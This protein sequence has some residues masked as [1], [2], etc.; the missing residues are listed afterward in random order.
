MVKIAVYAIAKNEQKHVWQFYKSVRDADIIV[1][2]CE[3]GDTTG[4]MLEA[5][6][7]KVIRINIKPFRFDTYRNEVLNSIPEDIDVCFSLDMDEVV[8]PDWRSIIEKHFTPGVTRLHYWMR[9]GDGEYDRFT[10]DRIHARHGYKW[11]HAIHECCITTNPL[12]D[13]A[14]EANLTVRHCPDPTKSRA[15]Y[16]QLLIDAVKE[17]PKSVRMN[18]YLGR[19]YLMVEKYVECVKQYRTY[20]KLMPTWAAEKCWAYIHMSRAYRAMKLNIEAEMSLH[21][22]IRVCKDLRDPYHELASIYYS[23]HRYAEALALV[24]E[25]LEIKHNTHNFFHSNNSY[26]DHIH[27]LRDSLRQQ[28]GY[29]PVEPSA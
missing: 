23:Q 19:E 16:L 20:L 12:K 17:D 4:D 10:C 7:V 3:P 6:D 8:Q 28:L 21:S 13:K 5:L 29:T 26:G 24:N 22:A 27:Q 9:W 25:A 11:V 15:S 1:V 2:G 18:W 14:A